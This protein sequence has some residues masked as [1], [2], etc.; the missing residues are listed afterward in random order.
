MPPAIQDTSWVPVRECCSFLAAGDKDIAAT[1]GWTG[2]QELAAT[3]Y[4]EE[5][6]DKDRRV[7]LLQ[8]DTTKALPLSLT[9]R[10]RPRGKIGRT[11]YGLF[12]RRAAL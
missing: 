5:D 4:G 8:I 3:G 10:P 6:G 11:P 9:F 1:G 7:D 2:E 12:P